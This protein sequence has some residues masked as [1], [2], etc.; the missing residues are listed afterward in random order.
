LRIVQSA[1]HCH[2]PYKDGIPQVP[3]RLVWKKALKHSA[4]SRLTFVSA[5]TL[6]KKRA[7]LVARN[8]CCNIFRADC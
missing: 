2:L 7:R 8:R 4:L 3:G 6:A 1:D 5:R